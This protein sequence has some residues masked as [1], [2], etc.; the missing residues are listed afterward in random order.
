MCAKSPI[1]SPWLKDSL[2]SMRMLGLPLPA[3]VGYI[4]EWSTPSVTA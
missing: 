3:V 1:N 4:S 2:L